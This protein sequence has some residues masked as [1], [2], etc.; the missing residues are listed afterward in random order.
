MESSHAHRKDE[1]VSLAQKY[2]NAAHTVDEFDQVR[3]IHRSFPEKSIDDISLQTCLNK[4]LI[5]DTPFYIEAMTGGS[6]KTEQL[7]RQ[8]AFLAAKHHLAM[9]SG[10]QSIALNDANA[11]S[12]FKIIREENPTG[13][14]FANLSAE[15]SVTRA[16]QAIEMLAANALELHVNVAQEL[17]MPEGSRTFR[18]L[19]N[20]EK[21]VNQLTVPI[22]VKEVGFGMDKQTLQQLVDVG[23]K[24][25]NV[26]GR[27]GTNF[28]QIENRRNHD[29]QF[30]DLKSWGQTTPESLLEAQQFNQKL[31]IFASGGISSPVDVIKSGILGANAVGVAGYFLHVLMTDGIDALDT[32][33]SN[34]ETEV[35]RLLLLCGV[36]KF[37]ELPSVPY[38]LSAE[39]NN[40]TKQRGLKRL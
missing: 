39:L 12:S 23:V 28:A 2:Y 9:A 5:L 34:W 6:D 15:T 20:I 26:S 32:V 40:Y 36:N 7:N 22:I 25:V 14:I 21:L 10:S 13:I 24:Y 8:L 29:N 11:I 3:I 27:G 37:Q 19:N 4:N 33:L 38:V 30:D 1:H 35:Q 31:T 18:W 17:T 16:N